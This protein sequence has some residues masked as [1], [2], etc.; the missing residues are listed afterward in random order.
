MDPRCNHGVGTQGGREFFRNDP[1]DFVFLVARETNHR[2]GGGIGLSRSDGSNVRLFPAPDGH[3]IIVANPQDSRL[4]IECARFG[5]YGSVQKF[6]P[7]PFLGLRP[8]QN[9]RTTSTVAPIIFPMPAGIIFH[10]N[11]ELQPGPSP[12]AMI[13][14]K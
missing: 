9:G 14:E 11:A 4:K 12:V 1:H 5:F 7:H 2:C 6:I 3:E 10:K 8:Y 13:S